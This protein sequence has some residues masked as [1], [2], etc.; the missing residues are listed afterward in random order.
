MAPENVP[1]AFVRVSVRLPSVTTLV[2]DPLWRWGPK[3]VGVRARIATPPVP[4]MAP[5]NEPLAF[6]R[7]KVRLPSVTTPVLAPD[8]ETIETP[9]LLAAEMSKVP[10][11]VTAEFAMLPVLDSPKVAPLAMVVAPL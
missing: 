7:V 9:A 8:N 4:P 1:L 3:I 11:A 2:A 5:A 10:L 6:N